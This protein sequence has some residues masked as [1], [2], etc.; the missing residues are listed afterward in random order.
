[1]ESSE[2]FQPVIV[3]LEIVEM[4]SALERNVFI[5]PSEIELFDE[6]TKLSLITLSAKRERFLPVVVMFGMSSNAFT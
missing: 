2:T 4:S 5:Q 6:E 1:M 3:I